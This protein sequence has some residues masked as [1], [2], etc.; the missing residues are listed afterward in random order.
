L[1]ENSHPAAWKK[2]A[3]PSILL[4][5]LA[6]R[7]AY[8]A[9]FSGPYTPWGDERIY[10]ELARNLLAGKGI[11][12][13]AGSC[14]IDPGNHP[15]SLWGF[16]YPA[17]LAGAFGL[18]D[19]SYRA[20]FLLQAILNTT[21]CA[22]VYLLTAKL[23]GRRAGIAA[24]LLSAGNLYYIYFVRSL[25]TEN[26][27]VP[28]FA[29]GVTVAFAAGESGSRKQFLLAGFCLGLAALTRS[30]AFYFLPFLL[31]ALYLKNPGPRKETARGVLL[32]AAA[33]LFTLA[34][35][36]V[37]N[38]I[39]H[40]R[41]VPLDTK[42][43]FNL[44]IANHPAHNGPWLEEQFDAVVERPSL[45]GMSEPDRDRYL[46][47]TALRFIADDPWRFVRLS[48]KK[49]Y[50]LWSPFPGRLTREAYGTVK[51]LYLLPFEL[52]AAAG[53]VLTR[54]RWRRLLPLY[55]PLLYF[56]LVHLVI[57]GGPRFR[58]PLD[59]FLTVFAAV[60]IAFLFD[61]SLRSSLG[62]GISGGV[63]VK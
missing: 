19:F 35:W 51:V 36:T 43:G 38:A 9:A 34:P 7:I 61:R 53:I 63:E 22:I 62:S 17:F 44:Y 32:A 27:F 21:I 50:Y 47:K 20:V 4:L 39:A 58:L 2:I 3:L 54:R 25:Y 12:T 14:F 29:L 26:L 40:G 6:V 56:S 28:L 31:A 1:N 37:R 8:A 57:L 60:P 49:L 13:D 10:E 59:P 55:A 11:S 42:A 46:V 41:F 24:A 48:T 45:P 52:L 23:F 30:V 5:A 33:F 18:F 16:L 15:T